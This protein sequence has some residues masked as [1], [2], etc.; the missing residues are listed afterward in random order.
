MR[1]N[2]FK[3]YLYL[4]IFS[5]LVVFTWY[6]LT[7]KDK[8][9]RVDV[10]NEIPQV[11]PQIRNEFV[12][13]NTGVERS[14][15]E[16]DEIVTILTQFSDTPNVTEVTNPVSTQAPLLI[17]SEL[18]MGGMKCHPDPMAYK[19]HLNFTSLWKKAEWYKEFHKEGIANINRGRSDLVKTLIWYCPDRT[20]GGL[21]YR[22]RG[23]IFNLF[24]AMFTNRVLILDWQSASAEIEYLKPNMIDWRWRHLPLI[25]R[26]E[27]IGNFVNSRKTYPGKFMSLVR[28]PKVQHL[29]AHY[30]AH[31]KFTASLMLQDNQI[32]ADFKHN[33]FKALIS[34]K[35]IVD[36]FAMNYLFRFSEDLLQQA[37]H[38][39]QSVG[40]LSY[41]ALHLR[42]GQFDENL[43][44]KDVSSRF[45]SNV[46]AWKE[47]IECAIRQAKSTIGPHGVV[48][49][50]SD[51]YK[52][53]KWAK[54]IYKDK[55]KILNTTI[56]HV[57]KSTDLRYSD[58]GML[59]IWQDLITMGEASVLVMKVSTFPELAMALCALSPN[60]VIDYTTCKRYI[61]K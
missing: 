9:D 59:G 17:P 61:Q 8:I 1:F 15:L 53:K 20:C 31:I 49:V 58:D 30:N 28:D 25:G 29:K 51:S 3:V 38:T 12:D 48:V 50:V 18:H 35:A 22:F 16:N 4:V 45:D 23:I 5:P 54:S 24:I 33:L 44:I 46:K 42:T 39:R 41:V 55:V 57:D 36:A 7:Q 37:Q 2:K 60:R 11:E 13:N 47:A 19:M 34:H 6:L 26:K 52:A 21:G 40:A 10:L 27:A 14:L 43:K 32:E 56:V